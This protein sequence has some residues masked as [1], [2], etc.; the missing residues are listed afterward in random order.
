[1]SIRQVR[2]SDLVVPHQHEAI[3]AHFVYDEF[4]RLVESY[5]A[6]SDADDGAKALKT[7]YQ[8]VGTTS[9]VADMKEEIA[10]W[11]AAWDF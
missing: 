9:K 6:L 7:S 2:P 10:Q 4:Q 11:D 3:K 1:M 5:T 8:Y